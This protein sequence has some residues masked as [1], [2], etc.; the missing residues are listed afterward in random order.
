MCVRIRQTWGVLGCCPRT[1]RPHM[2]RHCHRGSPQA[3]VF[4]RKCPLCAHGATTMTVVPWLKKH[5]LQQLRISIFA[6]EHLNTH[7]SQCIWRNMI[8]FYTSLNMTPTHDHAM[9]GIRK[10]IAQKVASS[11]EI[12]QS[13]FIFSVLNFSFS[14]CWLQ[15]FK[16]LHNVQ[17]WL[18]F[19][20][21]FYVQAPNFSKKN[22]IFRNRIAHTHL[23]KDS[24]SN[25][26]SCSRTLTREHS[27]V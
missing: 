10:T 16:Q 25:K 8:K 17:K 9:T 18:S 11:P 23:F 20:H 24:K 15:F 1:Q 27:I 14:R 12:E 26:F 7:L 5:M 19:L 6:L 21:C 22:A 13:S 4:T 2:L 3:S